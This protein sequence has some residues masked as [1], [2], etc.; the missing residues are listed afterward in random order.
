MKT[1]FRDLFTI[2]HKNIAKFIS[3]FTD[4]HVNRDDFFGRWRLWVTS[5]DT[6]L[7]PAYKFCFG[8]PTNFCLCVF[9][10]KYVNFVFLKRIWEP[11]NREMK[12]ML[13]DAQKTTNTSRTSLLNKMILRAWRERWKDFE[14]AI[15]VKTVSWLLLLILWGYRTLDRLILLFKDLGVMDKQMTCF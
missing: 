5:T 10:E 8:K 3:L 9:R 12:E 6:H 11:S 1:L 2:F 4:K 15:N 7:P 13:V 14:F